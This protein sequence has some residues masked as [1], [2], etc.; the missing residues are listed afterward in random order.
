MD[1][2]VLLFARVSGWNRRD[3]SYSLSPQADTK[4]DEELVL[5]KDGQLLVKG[6]E[7]GNP[8]KFIYL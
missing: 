7:E 2:D 6:S 3:R 5:R 1:E 8:N 4:F